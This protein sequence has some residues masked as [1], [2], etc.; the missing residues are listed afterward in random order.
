MFTFEFIKVSSYEGGLSTTGSVTI[1][2]VSNL[3]DVLK[4]KHV[5]IVE[6]IVDTGITLSKLLPKIENDYHPLTLEVCA[7]L[8][9]RT[10]HALTS[11]IESKF[12]GFSIP[13]LFV[14][15]FGLDFNQWY[16][17]LLDIWIISEEG[18]KHNGV[19]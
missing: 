14:L 18:I 5:I 13:D 17:D 8:E 9:K 19:F 10:P 1:K 7:M 11:R 16:R 2:E 6:D 12:V 15:G 4:G 3:K